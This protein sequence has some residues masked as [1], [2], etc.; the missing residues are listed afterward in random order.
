[1]KIIKRGML[2]LPKEALKFIDYRKYIYLKKGLQPSYVK[3]FFIEKDKILIPR[4]PFKFL[5]N[6]SGGKFEVEDQ[7]IVNSFNRELKTINGFQLRDYQEEP[8]NKV[9]ELF[10][11]GKNDVILVAG[12]GFGKEQPYSEPVL[13]PDGWKQMGDLKVGD[14]VIGS[15]GL[16][17]KIL[18]IYEQG[19]K[20]VYTVYFT[21]GAKVRCGLE[22]LWEVK[23]RGRKKWQ[24]KTLKELLTLVNKKTYDKRYKKTYFN[25]TYRVRLPKPIKGRKIDLPLDPYLLGVLLGDGGLTREVRITL[26]N[27]YVAQVIKEI[28]KQYSCDLKIAKKY[29]KYKKYRIIGKNGSNTITSIIRNLKLNKKSIEKHIPKMYLQADYYDRLKLL[30]GIID[31]DGYYITNNLVEITTSSEQL[32]KDIVELARSLGIYVSVGVKDNPSY[33]NLKG[34][35]IYCNTS[36]RIY[37]NFKK[38]YV[39]IEKIEKENYKEKSRCIYIDSEDHLY[40]TKDYILT[41][42]TATLSWL[43]TQMKQVT[44]ILVDLTMLAN[45]MYNEISKFSNLD[46]QIVNGKTTEAKEVNIVTVQLL[47]RRPDILQMLQKV[48]GLIVLDEAHISGAETIKSILQSFQ[49][50]YRLG[51]SATPTRSDGLDGILEDV[52][53]YKVK[54]KVTN[55]KVE[56][57]MVEDYENLISASSYRKAIDNTIKRKYIPFLD[58]IVDKLV[59]IKKKSIMIAVDNKE[60]QEMIAERYKKYGV[61]ILNSN[62][63]KEERERILKEYENENIKILI[64]YKVL[65]KGISIPRMEILINLF[66]AT[67]K[68]NIEQL[69]GRLMREHPKKQK[70]IFIDFT[71]G[72]SLQKQ[73]NV[74]INTYNKLQKENKIILKKIA[75]DSYKQIL[76]KIR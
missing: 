13:T 15:D 3:N 20:E 17:K 76:Q 44:T 11:K 65:S 57:H 53:T 37:L 40:I 10:K 18:G 4:N 30:Q 63:T 12:T 29:N 28:V 34:E 55:M 2:E 38:D 54:T 56:V 64:G 1:M 75:L 73:Y 39:S 33:V 7:T 46:V 19:E 35:R 9:L 47:N 26:S 16:P 21:N 14:F 25:R 36:Y 70:A 45:Q 74:K 60:I 5:E 8:M 68:E 48:T 22:H 51:L 32:Y 71:F 61:G 52:F 66:A 49:A 23:R 50:R 41:H 58:L 62:T 69:V 27:D 59:G 24:V 6:W 72:L 42:N 31:T 43:L 67:T